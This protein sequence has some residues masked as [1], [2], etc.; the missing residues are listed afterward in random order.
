MLQVKVLI[1]HQH[2]E[3]KSI[4]IELLAW[5]QEIEPSSKIVV[6]LKPKCK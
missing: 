6:I 3:K 5:T 1:P 4:K 2:F